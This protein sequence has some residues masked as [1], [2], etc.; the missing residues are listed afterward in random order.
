VIATMTPSRRT[1]FGVEVDALTMD[2][3]L[4]RVFDCVADGRPVQHVVVNAAK[5]VLM[6]RDEHL[7]S[8]IA[9]CPLVNADGTSVVWASRILGQPLPERVTGIDLFVEIVGRAAR[10]GHRVYFLGARD[11]VLDEMLAR[12][13]ERFPGLVVAGHRNGYWDDD[14]AVIDEVRA[15]APDFLFLAIPSPRKEYWLAEHAEALGVPFVM[16]VGGS[17]DVLAGKVRRAPVW[18][19]RIGGEWLYRLCQEP[20][21][22]WKRYLVGNTT[23][24][25]LVARDWWRLR[26][27]KVT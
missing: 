26:I 15:T 13:R 2:E 21:R 6:H 1:L 16:G 9:Q 23:F 18:V 14:D 27:R 7:R 17:F 8:I 10:T 11:D 24:I 12:F 20:R 22:M 25:A 5:V 19:Q 3:T 4:E